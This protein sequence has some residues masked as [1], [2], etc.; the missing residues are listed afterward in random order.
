MFIDTAITQVAHDLP[1]K[2]GVLIITLLLMAV[3]DVPWWQ[4]AMVGVVWAVCLWMD[5]MRAIPIHELSAHA[6]D[7]VWYLG[8]YDGVDRQVWQAYLSDV[9]AM[10]RRVTMTFR[11]VV[12]FEITH[13]V[14]IHHRMV[15]EQDFRRLVSLQ[16]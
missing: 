2:A 16:I 3:M 9:A 11:V 10:G 7:D 14:T 1:I 4:Y 8:M 15:S 12:P 6:P 13:R 5:K